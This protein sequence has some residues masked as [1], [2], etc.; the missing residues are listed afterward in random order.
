MIVYMFGE[1]TEIT[2]R[3]DKYGTPLTYGDKVIAIC[4]KGYIYRAY[5]LG[6]TTSGK[7]D[8][9]LQ[10]GSMYPLRPYYGVLKYDWKVPNSPTA[11]RQDE[12]T[13]EILKKNMPSE[14]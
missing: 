1:K 9:V 3:T 11:L 12:E 6:T 5:Y 13:I 10:L 7:T 4:S 14:L 2:G 8:K